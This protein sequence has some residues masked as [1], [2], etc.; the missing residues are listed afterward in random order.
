MNRW[1]AMCWLLV[2]GV[3]ACS[4]ESVEESPDADP[5]DILFGDELQ[6]CGT[7]A[8]CLSGLCDKNWLGFMDEGQGYCAVM[9]NTLHRWQRE[10]IAVRL[11]GKAKD[12]PEFAVRLGSRMLEEWDQSF[13]TAR[14][15]ALILLAGELPGATSEAVL[16]RAMNSEGPV[17]A[18]LAG[19]RLAARGGSAGVAQL[20]EAALSSHAVH[21]IHAARAA[22]RRCDDLARGILRELSE[23]P[24]PLVRD[25]ASQAAAGCP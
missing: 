22:G 14:R 23:D 21:R 2:M 3:A 11:A 18:M 12:D 24:H 5:L 9:G 20:A 15:E 8:E 10:L 17:L 19:V 1:M 7:D 25:V 4:V 6:L 16:E 13:T